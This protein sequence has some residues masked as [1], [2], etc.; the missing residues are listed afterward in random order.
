MSKCSGIPLPNV[1]WW[2]GTKVLDSTVEERQEG[3]VLTTFD[4]T[5]TAATNAITT[6]TPI[7]SYVTNTLHIAAV[8]R[9]HLTHNLTCRAANTPVF[10]PLTAPV[11]LTQTGK[12]SSQGK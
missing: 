12:R 11:L 9:Y 10:P 2:S 4:S 1:T 3:G 5:T 6:L 8:T 7:S